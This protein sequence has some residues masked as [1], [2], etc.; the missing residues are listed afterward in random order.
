MV[1]LARIETSSPAG[2]KSPIIACQI[3][4]SSFESADVQ[5][6]FAENGIPP[7]ASHYVNISSIASSASEFL[8]LGAPALAKARHL[9]E[10]ATSPDVALS[11]P[12]ISMNVIFHE[13]VKRILPPLDGRSEV[14][15]FLC[16]GMNYVDHCEE[17]GIQV[18]QVPVVFSKFGS[19]IVG[20]GDFIPRHGPSG[21]KSSQ[22]HGGMTA[23]LDEDPVVT[24]KLD[25]EVEL[26]I[27]IGST[28]PRFTSAEDA[29]KYI[30]GY[31]VIH[32]VSAR[33]LQLEANGGQWLLGKCGD[34]YAPIGPVIATLDEFLRS[35]CNDPFAGAGDLHIECRLTQK[36]G[37]SMTVQSSSTSNLVFSTPQIVSY[38]SKFMTLYPG[39]TIATGTPPGVGCFRKPD[40]LFLKDG[41]M[42]EC[43]IEGIGIL[44]N[45]VVEQLRLE[46]SESD[47]NGIASMETKPTSAHSSIDIKGPPSRIDPSHDSLPQKYRLKNTVAIV[48]GAAR[49]IGFGIALRL[50][51]EGAV[52]VALI[53]MK[54]D[55][56]DDAASQLEKE[57]RQAHAGNKDIPVERVF[58][59]LAC[60]VTKLDKVT[61]TFRHVANTLSPNNR[62]DI[63]VQA[64]GVVGQT[65]L[66]THQVNEENFDFVMS[67]NVKGIFNGC[68]ACL[69]YMLEQNYGRIINIA[70]IAGKE[71]NA[72]MLAYSTSKAAVIGLTKTI[73][74]EYA[75]NGI[76]CNAI[77]P[78]VVQTKMVADMPAEQVKYMTD[79]IPMKRCGKVEEVAALVAFVASEEAGFTTGF[80]WDATGGR[81]VY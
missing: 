76:T 35:D 51:L 73:G 79:K 59:G 26:G 28:V 43:E 40:P 45:T 42:I 32:D 74:K 29:H 18:P 47:T 4:S 70:S 37:D 2:T 30:G 57:L 19:C 39:D 17:Q 38:L 52:V 68:H 65:N 25:F 22:T 62:I 54:Q 14:G 60:D 36:E 23:T 16:I 50:A 66:L 71:G 46:T 80:C 8:S 77:A 10:K 67:I 56:L 12:F 24:S 20:P 21:G 5:S 9:I 13:K 48:T 6:Y 1:K 64:A 78:A 58:Y 27:V 11:S 33:D 61:D 49:G 15:K 34:G 44:R 53:D 63:L 69:P 55:E 75:L 81:S 41:D 72:G 31:T 7:S 3:L